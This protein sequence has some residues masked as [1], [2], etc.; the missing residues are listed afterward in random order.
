[1]AVCGAMSASTRARVSWAGLRPLPLMPCTVP[2]VASKNRQKQSPPMP[3]LLQA[4]EMRQYVMG[5]MN[6]VVDV[7]NG[8]A[9]GL[10]AVQRSRH[11]HSG[12]RCVAAGAQ[13][14]AA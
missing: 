1:M 10:G 7:W 9:P 4:R 2:R 6:R 5:V 12:V 8:D 14:P 3:V 11:G 13:D